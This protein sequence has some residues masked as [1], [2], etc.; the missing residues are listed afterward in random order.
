MFYTRVYNRA[1]GGVLGNLGDITPQ[2][3]MLISEE[4]IAVGKVFK[5]RV[6]L[7]IGFNFSKPSLDF[8][9]RSVWTKPD[10]DPHF[11]NTGF[12]LLNVLPSD[13]EIITRMMETYALRE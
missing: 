4:P 11:Y 9:G 7:P 10:L 3:A 2:G 6:E 5:M 13:T 8:D 12:Q 1:T